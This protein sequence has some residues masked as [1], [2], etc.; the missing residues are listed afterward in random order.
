VSRPATSRLKVNPVLGS[1]PTLEWRPVGELLIDPAY[2]RAID[3]GP[4]QTLI[5]RIAMFWDWGLCQPL[6]VSRRPDGALTIVDGQHR[7]E[8]AKLRGDVPH[9]PCVITSYASAG[10]EAAA[11]VALN[12]QRR[13]L[14]ALDL[15][16]A[17]VAAEDKE[18]LLILDCITAAGLSLA[19]HSNYTCWKPGMV[20]NISSIQR[21]YRRA[22]EAA[23][24][25]ALNAMAKSWPGEVLQ[26]AGSVF[27][28][29]AAVAL[30]EVRLRG[31]P[32]EVVSDLAR[33]AGSRS[34]AEWRVAARAAFNEAGGVSLRDGAEWVFRQAW[35]ARH[36]APATLPRPTAEPQPPS[37]SI[38]CTQ[39]DQRVSGAKANACA[40]PFCAAKAKAA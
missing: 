27:C 9:L 7:A 29:F 39:C 35:R 32:D 2:Q 1:P 19:P 10:D 38:W 34:Q 4:S 15:F 23:L 12:Q 22:N 28:G 37:A 17:A 21:F 8:A 33:I 20:A 11:F 26:Y 24:R 5:R 18:A 3:T 6:A 31:N 25:I 30:D 16:K 40:S 36:N 13:P 14:Q